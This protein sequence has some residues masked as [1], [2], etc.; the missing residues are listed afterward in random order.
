MIRIA[1]K[2]T[3]VIADI[4]ANHFRMLEPIVTRAVEQHL[5]AR[6][7]EYILERLER[8]LIGRPADLVR[9]HEN[10]LRFC[11]RN[12]LQANRGMTSAFSYDNFG[13]R[14]S[15]N[16]YD[17][18]HLLKINVC[19]YCNRQ[20]TFTISNNRD[21]IT[22]PEFDH[23]FC[24]ELYPMLA[25]S[26]YNLVPSCVI[27]NSR[28]KGRIDFRLSTHLN[29]F[30]YGFETDMQFGYYTP[31][32]D[33]AIGLS[34]D[35][36]ITLNFATGAANH[37]CIKGNCDIFRLEP[38]YQEHK[39]TVRE[40]IRKHYTTKG[41]Y[42]QMLAHSIPAMHTTDAELYLLAFGNYYDEIDFE[43][44]PLGKLTK[45]IF[46]SLKFDLPII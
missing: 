18:A 15:Y 6:Q 28:L 31:T 39:D 13:Q 30:L 20:Y 14:T 9:L 12:R 21:G 35:L 2:G 24:Q 37:T 17:L 38:I 42:L 26:F 34:E 11:R 36:R 46:N 43:R 3:R 5:P 44:R 7:G 32:T 8:I 27:C 33:A 25:L 4:A 10:Y 1:D 16:L 29:P 45:D 41:K 22:R 40:I 23:F 19:P